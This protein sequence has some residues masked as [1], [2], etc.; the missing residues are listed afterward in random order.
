MN[1]YIVKGGKPLR[2]GYTTGSCATA[3]ASASA[4]MLLHGEVIDT[5]LVALPFGDRVAFCIDNPVITADM[6]SCSVKKDAGDDPDV[7]DGLDIVVR[8]QRCAS[9][10][11]IRG[12]EGIGTVTVDGL[13]LPKGESAI[14]P[15]PRRMILENVSAVCQQHGYS[16]G[17]VLT[18]AAPG[19]EAI[20][21]KTF[22][23]RLGIVGGIS[24]LGTTGIVEPMSEKAMLDTI[25]LLID[26]R[27]AQDPDNI[28]VAP[29]NYGLHFCRDS[30]GLDTAQV[31]KFANFLGE[32]LD[33]I[34]YKQFRRVLLVG[35]AGKLVKAAG[36]IMQT[37]SAIA[38]CRMEILAAHAACAGAGM[39]T[40][41][42]I[43]TA[44][45]TDGAI[46]ILEQSGY[47]EQSLQT[48]LERLQ[49]HLDNRVGHALEIGVVVFSQNRVLVQSGNAEHLAGFFSGESS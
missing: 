32:C 16:G 3:A 15:A 45:T 22:N 39:A 19:G 30:L 43:M 13:S 29:G 12:G 26:R 17:L 24:I 47:G 35:H 7:T 20:A 2:L 49:F 14:N 6:A 42:A 4:S 41:Q 23:P 10:L 21:Q 44:P 11:H 46:A 27:K 40:V 1:D 31:V 33:Y 34:V 25:R 36:G 48:L 38:D 9:G 28:L 8:C 5:V 18:V 37:H